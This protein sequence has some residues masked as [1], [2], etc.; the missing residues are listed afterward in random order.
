[1]KEP[2]FIDD[3]VIGYIEDH[4]FTQRVLQRHI[5]RRFNAKGIDA[6]LYKR[7]RAQCSLWRLQL[8][9]GEV[10]EIPFYLIPQVG[11]EYDTGAGLQIL[12]KLKDFK[13]EQ[14]PIQKRLMV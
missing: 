5:F 11:F 13:V 2:V 6:G 14:K 1:M 10:L 12:V 4:T 8:E 7:L 9:T 3:I